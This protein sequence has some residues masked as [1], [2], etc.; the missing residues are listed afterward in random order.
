[1]RILL[2]QPRL[3]QGIGF[4]LAASPEPLHLEMIAATVPEHDV[5]ILDMRLDDDLDFMLRRFQPELVAVTALT[6]EVYA[7]QDV[8]C[9][10]KSFS[11]EV[12]TVAGGH[13]ATLL[14]ED[15]SL[16]QVD[17]VAIG[18]AEVMFAP[19]VRAVE[20]HL[21][22]HDVPNIV[23]QNREGA[24]IRNGQSHARIDLGNLPMPRRNL[25]EAYRSEY[26]FLFDKPDTSVATSRGCPFRCNF[27]SVHEFYHGAINQMPA[28]RVLS[29][30]ADVTTDH[31]TF[32]D[33]NFLMNYKREARIA[34]MIRSEGIRK[35]YSMECR[36]DSIVRHP[37]LVKNWVDIG[38]YAV[39][40]GLEGGS[41]KV[42]QGVGKSCTIDTNNRAIQILQDNGVIIWGAF[43][44][45][46][47][48]TQDDFNRLRDYVCEHRI[49]HTQ[50]T[51]LTPL[52]GTQLYRERR[53][54][55]L[56]DDY[57]CFDTLHA[58]LPTRLPRE[59][60][61]QHFAGLYR[62]TDIGPYYDLV[63][64]GKMTIED[65]RRGKAMLDAMADWERYIE[66]DPILGGRN[67]Y[68]TNT[69]LTQAGQLR[70][71]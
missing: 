7:A 71:L 59:E 51:I 26:F 33:D 56:T 5:R 47:D 39:L 16:P 52:P 58:V 22:L 61:Y 28:G 54:E 6:P 57:S 48:W 36:T 9:R 64:S 18:E 70:R 37:D 15:F 2:V 21:S 40:L 10:V 1:V 3:S 67:T 12:F 55:L 43:I 17:A 42:L 41:D 8:L 53:N 60:F 11:P 44:V 24:F 32:V 19:L 38:L 50:F 25:T 30:V 62:Q 66:K 68:S 14:P 49:T 29:E 69:Q 4:P 45:D 27:C 20:D 31:I 63:Q 13:H 65:C 46:P 35:R 34:D 23:W